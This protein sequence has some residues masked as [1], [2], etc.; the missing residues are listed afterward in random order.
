MPPIVEDWR[1]LSNIKKPFGE[2][3][4]A[5]D[6]RIFSYWTAMEYQLKMLTH[7]IKNQG[8]DNSIYIIIGDHNPGG[9]EY[10]LFNKFN[11]WATPIHIISKDADFVESFHQHGFTEGMKV[12]TSKFT[13]MR[14]MGLYSLLTRQLLENYGEEDEV[15][16]DYLPYGL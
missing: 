7:Y 10:K 3:V 9:L 6:M 8:Q 13:I 4:I 15:L 16:P 2:E 5:K 11:K 14:H 12:D 1:T